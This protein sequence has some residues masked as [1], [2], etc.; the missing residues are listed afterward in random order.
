MT[1]FRG[2]MELKGAKSAFSWGKADPLGATLGGIFD[3]DTSR[4][5]R[6]TD[7]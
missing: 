3:E 4:G 6:Y 5:F 7:P 1:I 2:V